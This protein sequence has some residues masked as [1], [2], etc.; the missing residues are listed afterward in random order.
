MEK[1]NDKVLNKTEVLKKSEEISKKRFAS[2]LIFILIIVIGLIGYVAYDKFQDSLEEK[3]VIMFQE[4]AQYG[5]QLLL[6][7]IFYEA[8]ICNSIP[9]DNGSIV[10]NLIDTECLR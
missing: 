4:G 2:P 1:P 6:S 8:V 7:E 5:A 10:V 3:E 9:I